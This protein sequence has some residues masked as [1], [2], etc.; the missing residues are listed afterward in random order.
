MQIHADAMIKN[1]IA[2]LRHY[3]S[4]C[5]VHIVNLLDD[6][7]SLIKSSVDAIDEKI[8]EFGASKAQTLDLSPREV[9]QEHECRDVHITPDVPRDLLSKESEVLYMSLEIVV[10]VMEVD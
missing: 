5:R 6:G 9:N 10:L 2:E 8:T 3:Y 4:E 1:R 7:K